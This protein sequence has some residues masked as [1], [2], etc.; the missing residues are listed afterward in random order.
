M[1]PDRGRGASEAGQ[2]SDGPCVIPR[3][4]AGGRGP[5]RLTMRRS[6]ALAVAAVLAVV[7]TLVG[8][9]AAVAHGAGLAHKRH[10][11]AVIGIHEHHHAGAQRLLD[12]IEDAHARPFIYV[13]DLPKM[14][15]EGLFQWSTWWCGA[16]LP[17]PARTTSQTGTER[18]IKCGWWC[19]AQARPCLRDRH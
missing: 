1:A 4:Q 8:P 18:R 5:R 2:G 7:A 15:N 9:A 3:S 17:P 6:A 10:A 19:G 13:Y 11:K 12:L 14:F 16:R